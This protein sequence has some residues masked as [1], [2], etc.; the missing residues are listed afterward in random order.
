MVIKILLSI[1]PMILWW[2]VGSSQKMFSATIQFP[3]ELDRNHIQLRYDNGKNEIRIKTA[4]SQNKVTVAD[5]FYAKYATIIV[6][7]LDSS[8]DFI[9][10]KSFFITDK[11]AEIIFTRQSH[12]PLD[13]FKLINAYDVEQRGARELRLFDSPERQ[14]FEVFMKTNRFKLGSNDSLQ[15]IAG[16]KGQR[17]WEKKLE[18]IEQNGGLYYSFW[19]FRRDI[20]PRLFTNTDSLL[21]IFNS[22]FPDS[23]KLSMEGEEILKVLNGRILTRKNQYAPDFTTVDIEGKRIS[24]KDYRGKYVILNFWASWCVPCL[25]EIPSL[26]Q[27][28]EKY[29]EDRLAIISITYDTDT[30]AFL[31]AIQK[32][33]MDW[34]HVYN[35]EDLIKRYGDQAVPMV[36]LLDKNGKV[37]YGRNEDQDFKEGN[38]ALLNEILQNRL[39]RRGSATLE[40]KPTKPPLN[41]D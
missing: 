14:E 2:A 18:F 13:E 7:Y 8:G 11:P 31:N 28:R 17:L 6:N 41:S 9:N 19:L 12:N 3:S 25:E 35:D 24:L 30:T 1:L 34:V 27:F 36:Y 37:I 39:W 16:E 33:N 22:V 15:M 26:K 32:Y 4:I 20:I 40:R 5:S 29:P 38:L 10:S 23:L 21:E